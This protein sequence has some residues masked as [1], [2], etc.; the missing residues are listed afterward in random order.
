[1][2]MNLLIHD[3]SAEEW[4]QKKENY[5]GWNVISPRDTI[6]PCIG[7]FRCWT[8][9]TGECAVRDGYESMG[10]LLHEAEEVVV[11]S[12]YTY[13]GF[14]S[15][16]KNV[17]DRSLGYVLPEFETAYHEMHHKK[18]YAE[19]KPVTFVFRGSGLSETE[20]RLAERYVQAVCRN[21]RGTVKDVLFEECEESIGPAVKP[22]IGRRSGTLIISCSPRGRRS[23]TEVFLDRLEKE[24]ETPS[25]RKCLPLSGD[26]ENLA[27][28]VGQ[29]ET[30][31]LGMPLYVDGLP[32]PAIRFLD[33]V[34]MLG[35]GTGVRLYAVVNNGL[36]ESR[37]NEN[38]LAMLNEWC[39]QSG[40]VY[41]GAAAIGAGEAVGTL[42]R[43]SNHPLWP[44]DNAVKAL[45]ALAESIRAGRETETVYAD[46]SGFPRWLYILIANTNWQLLK[47]RERTQKKSQTTV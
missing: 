28:E 29:A 23:N 31:I 1:M 21:L 36:Y 10:A 14:S 41:C 24:L 33:T 8:G 26:M 43:G 18:R 42:M 16:V 3:L 39:R 45:G 38:L 37:Q 6:H 30:V 44:A 25:E 22:K 2:L 9:S 40:A 47:H 12:R 19:D 4:R 13:G 20:K 27:K 11:M 15:F 34:R 32:A 17:F 5:K 35:T 7:C 46:P